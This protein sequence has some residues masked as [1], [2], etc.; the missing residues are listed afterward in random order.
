MLCR[1]L[2]RL[3]KPELRRRAKEVGAPADEIEEARDEDD[4]KAAMVQLILKYSK[5][6][7]VPEDERYED[8]RN[9]QTGVEAGS[10][11]KLVRNKDTRD[12]CPLSI[13]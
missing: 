12:V 8:I 2:L 10:T 1:A 9:I 13:L 4:E 7:G 3:K 6:Q 5:P 11:V